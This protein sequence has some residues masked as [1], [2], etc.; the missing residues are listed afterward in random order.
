MKRKLLIGLTCLTGLCAALPASAQFAKP[1]DA[2]KYRK[3]A[4]TV[5]AN[6][7]GRISAMAQGKVPFD[8][9]AA[10]AN[11]EI[12]ATMA[13]LPFSAFPEGTH[14]TDKGTPKA[15]VWSERAKFDE[16]AKALQA[17]SVKLVAAAKSNNLDALKA[18]MG[19]TGKTC[20]SC[21]DNFRNE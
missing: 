19:N 4:F 8:A 17:E 20:K 14:G 11:A 21:H 10:S 2:V 3:A 6:H 5:M 12:V 1:E 15:S 16:G 7:F 13:M 9:A 18:A